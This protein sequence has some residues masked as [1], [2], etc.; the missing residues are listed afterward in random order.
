MQSRF[1]AL[2]TNT[3]G[4]GGFLSLLDTGRGFCFSLTYRELF[5]S[6]RSTQTDTCFS[7]FLLT[8]LFSLWLFVRF[9]LSF[10]MTETLVKCMWS[11]QRDLR[12]NCRNGSFC[13]SIQVNV[14]LSCSS[15]CF[16]FCSSAYSSSSFFSLC[17]LLGL[18]HLIIFFE[19]RTSGFQEPWSSR[20]SE[21]ERFEK[22]S[23]LASCLFLY[24]GDLGRFNLQSV[25]F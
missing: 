2:K 14:M 19:P 4:E 11:L 5:L 20:V 3:L 24:A 7:P 18:Q 6:L 25:R 12:F 15:S 16:S 13:F 17:F 9:R 1:L 21:N 22:W 10:S 23:C 8:Q